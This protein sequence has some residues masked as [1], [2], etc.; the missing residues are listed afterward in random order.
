MINEIKSLFLFSLSRS[1]FDID[2]IK[3]SEDDDRLKAIY[4]LDNIDI[5]DNNKDGGDLKTGWKLKESDID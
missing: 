5:D 1:R 2:A 4:E 3:E